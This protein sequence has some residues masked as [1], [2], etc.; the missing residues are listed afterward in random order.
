L[1]HPVS[2]VLGGRLTRGQATDEIR[3]LSDPE[4]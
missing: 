2:V 4:R 1:L 3:R